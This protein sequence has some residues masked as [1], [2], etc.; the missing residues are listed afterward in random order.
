MATAGPTP[1][2]QVERDQLT[3][4]C[5]GCMAPADTQ[6]LDHC[7]E[8]WRVFRARQAAGMLYDYHDGHDSR[9]SIP[10]RDHPDYR[11]W[12]AGEKRQNEFVANT[13]QVGIAGVGPDVETVENEAGAKQSNVPYRMDLVDARAMFEMTRVL[14]EGADKYGPGN[15]RGIPIQDH[16]NHLLVHAYAYLAGDT[17]DDHL[18]HLMC[19]AMFAQA[20]ALPNNTGNIGERSDG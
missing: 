15:W 12:S 18:A 14:A 8:F 10:P 20:V 17:S 5:F 7:P 2:F 1:E 9:G 11:T 16:L 19:R 3:G 6:H 4:H 13:A